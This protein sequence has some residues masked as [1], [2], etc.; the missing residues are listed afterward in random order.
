M[1]DRERPSEF[2]LVR[3]LIW[4]VEKRE[5]AQ[6]SFLW[7]TEADW[8]PQFRAGDR[9]EGHSTWQVPNGLLGAGM[10]FYDPHYLASQK[11]FRKVC[12]IC[13]G[14]CEGGIFGKTRK[15][16]EDTFGQHQS[17]DREASVKHRTGKQNSAELGA[18]ARD[19]CENTN[20]PANLQTS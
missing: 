8:Q 12:T 16:A 15:E 20:L 6:G 10:P 18:R 4:E 3:R 17:R 13:A 19:H 11:T 14:L 9:E 1:K 2:S 5:V 7:G